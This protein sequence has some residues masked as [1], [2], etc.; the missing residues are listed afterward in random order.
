ME[1]SKAI[2]I[3]GVVLTIL[4]MVME[5]LSAY[6]DDKKMDEKIAEKISEALVRK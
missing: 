6:V 3:L 2:R 1:S 5:P 4:G